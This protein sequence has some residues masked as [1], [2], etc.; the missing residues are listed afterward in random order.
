VAGAGIDAHEIDTAYGVMA[1]QGTPTPLPTP[2]PS[3]ISVKHLDFVVTPAGGQIT[4]R[5]DGTLAA[6]PFPTPGVIVVAGPPPNN[7][8]QITIQADPNGR[9][10]VITPATWN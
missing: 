7:P 4:F 6:P 9:V 5:G 3:L 10:R 8:N 1:V 2:V